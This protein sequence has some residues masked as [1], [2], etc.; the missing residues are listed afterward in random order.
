MYFDNR[1]LMR[2]LGTGRK[3]KVYV[4]QE[5]VT[6]TSLDDLL[7]PDMGYGYTIYGEPRTFDYKDIENVMSGTQ[8]YTIDDLQK[9]GEKY[10]VGG[11]DA[12]EEEDA[13]ADADEGGEEEEAGDEEGGEEEE[14]GDEEG[15][16]EIGRAHV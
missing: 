11:E 7:N 6:I 16:D 5:Y 13:D 4:N 14:A 2:Y 8:I 15:G 12:G 3:I 1:F 10:T 9:Y